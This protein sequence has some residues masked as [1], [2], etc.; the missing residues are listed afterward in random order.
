MSASDGGVASSRVG[1]GEAMLAAAAGGDFTD[2]RS[3]ELVCTWFIFMFFPFA[4]CSFVCFEAAVAS[5]A[6]QGGDTRR[7]KAPKRGSRTPGKLFSVSNR[8]LHPK[9]GR[10]RNIGH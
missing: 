2:P 7:G 3:G 10:A 9:P 4:C 1:F 6:L 5:A 8:K